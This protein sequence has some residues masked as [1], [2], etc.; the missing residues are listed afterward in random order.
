[1]LL[2]TIEFTRFHWAIL[3]GPRTETEDSEGMRY[4]AKEELTP[5]GWVWKYEER[6][7]SVLPTQKLLVR[8]QIGK[9]E[10]PTQC[11]KILRETP[12]RG[13]DPQWNCVYWVEEALSRLK[14]D[15]R[16]VGTGS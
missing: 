13:T 15:G 5:D 10:N 1:M 12:V 14:S 11:A 3:T 6:P 4:H 16:A 8:I 7:I 9:L 2:F